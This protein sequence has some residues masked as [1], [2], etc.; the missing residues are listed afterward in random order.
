MSA[1][2]QI[3]SGR[4]LPCRDSLGGIKNIYI[5]SGS[6][7]GVTAASGAISDISGS[8][9][10]YKF[11]LEKGIGSW[12]ETPTP[13]L[14]NGTIYYE[15]AIEVSFH[16]MDAALRN[17]VKVLGENTTMR[18]V[19]ETEQA[20]TDYSGRFFYVGENRGCYLT[21]GSGNTGV[22]LGDSNAYSLTLSGQEPFPCQEVTTTGN[23]TDALTG[24][25][26]S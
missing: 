17:Q 20:S 5:L 11:Q 14:E 24:I 12:T 6:V 23:L 19:V 22:A 15:E 25:T 1:N 9:I 10:F 4:T 7:A 21:A 26:V 3:T 13:S 16:K 18:I 2:C 8:G